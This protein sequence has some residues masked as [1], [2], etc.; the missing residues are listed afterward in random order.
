[1]TNEYHV[2][3]YTPVCLLLSHCCKGENAEWHQRFNMT[4]GDAKLAEET[5]HQKFLDLNKDLISKNVLIWECE[6]DFQMSKSSD[7]PNMKKF[8]NFKSL[9]RPYERLVL[10]TFDNFITSELSVS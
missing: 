8:I 3:M 1:M 10:A 2:L 9:K 6:Y 4:F 5:K 7:D